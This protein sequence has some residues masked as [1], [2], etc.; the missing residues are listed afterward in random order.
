MK[1]YRKWGPVHSKHRTRAGASGARACGRAGGCGKE[2]RVCVPGRVGA[3][4]GGAG[5]AL[6]EETRRD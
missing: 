3:Q 5:T 6:V 2:G 4:W 1:K